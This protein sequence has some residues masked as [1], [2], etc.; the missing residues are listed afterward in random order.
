MPLDAKGKRIL[1][2]PA[3][4][5]L[6]DIIIEDIVQTIDREG[7]YGQELRPIIDDTL[8]DAKFKSLVV[9]LFDNIMKYTDISPRE[10]KEVLSTLMEED[11]ADD[12]KR[13]LED[14][15]EEHSDT[16]RGGRKD[17]LH[18]NGEEKHLWR[19]V[20]RRYL[21]SRISALREIANL[22][23]SN[24]AVQIT[25][26]GGVALLVISSLLFGSVYEAVIAGLTLTAITAESA[27]DKLAN[28]LGALGGILIFFVTLSLIFQYLFLARSRDERIRDIAARYLQEKRKT[29]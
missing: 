21:G 23:S 3:Y 18:G 11:I 6:R 19:D 5:K 25:F 24:T 28:V 27:R 22:I 20:P 26:V 15:L 16:G 13:G 10:C 14:N 1:K 9:K 4:E 17:R 7:R 8:K 2:E 29:R 12:I